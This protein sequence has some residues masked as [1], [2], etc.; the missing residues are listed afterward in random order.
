MPVDKDESKILTGAF[1][2]AVDFNG[3]GKLSASDITNLCKYIA[4]N[5]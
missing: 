1:A 3:D 2:R 4:E 5:K